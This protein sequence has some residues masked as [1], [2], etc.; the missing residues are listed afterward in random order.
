MPSAARER[1]ASARPG[2]NSPHLQKAGFR[3]PSSL[4]A[5]ES[6]ARGAG[7]LACYGR[8][9]VP[10]VYLFC[11]F[12]GPAM[13][14]VCFSA[15]PGRA[16]PP[17]GGGLPT[18]FTFTRRG[19]WGCLCLARGHRFRPLPGGTALAALV[20]GGHAGCRCRVLARERCRR[21][22][23]GAGGGSTGTGKTWPPTGDGFAGHGPALFPASPLTRPAADSAVGA[24]GRRPGS[25]GWAGTVSRTGRP[26]SRVREPA[27]VPHRQ[28]IRV[29][30]RVPADSRPPFQGRT[31]RT[32]RE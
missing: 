14:L 22:R 30:I 26:F 11:T 5:P 2:R 28:L 10:G 4:F 1:L 15:G 29:P 13:H 16:R 23:R 31:C 19:P 21:S 32:R 24:E 3:G 20:R 9:D 6:G 12:R 8:F 7:V 25:W 27:A 18:V 17:H